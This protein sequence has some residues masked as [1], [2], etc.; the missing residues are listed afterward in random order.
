MVENIIFLSSSIFTKFQ[1]CVQGYIA[2]YALCIGTLFSQHVA[3]VEPDWR[4]YDQ[5]LTQYV[6]PGVLAGVALNQV[7]YDGLARDPRFTNV[8][9]MIAAFPVAQ[10]SNPDETLAFYINVYNVLALNMV[11]ENLPVQSIKDIGNLFRPV[12]KR[13][14]G[15]VGG[16]QVTLHVVEHEILRTLNEPRIHFAI[17]CASVSCP[18]LR[19]EAYVAGRLNSQLDDQCRNFLNNSD[20]GL[21]ETTNK[22][23]VSKICKWFEEDFDSQGGI[24]SFIRRYRK[25]P[26]SVRI[27]PAIDY[28]WSLNSQ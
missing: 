25:L 7:D 21:R 11:T 4:E 6:S 9:N 5:L 28:N 26:A 23:E 8:V 1:I 24:A 13:P 20:K 27:D 16:Q 18:D 15:M 19:V 22:L 14:A 10:L 17:V 2:I 12:W 3:A